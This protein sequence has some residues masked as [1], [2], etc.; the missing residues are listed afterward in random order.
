MTGWW[1]EHN[2]DAT[3][4]GVLVVSTF[5]ENLEFIGMT[6]FLLVALAHF[7]RFGRPVSVSAVR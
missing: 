3:T 5:E 2:E 6:I 7:A 1:V 4:T